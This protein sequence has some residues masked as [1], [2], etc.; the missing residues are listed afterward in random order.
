MVLVSGLVLAGG[1]SNESKSPDVT[2]SIR[3]SLDQAGLKDVSVS[4]D[5]D[6][7]VVTLS[8]SVASDSDKGQA[9]S[10]AKG[11]AGAMVVADQIAVRPPGAESMAKDIDADLDK[12]IEKNLDAALLQNHLN[13]E[14]S[15]DVK[16][17]VVTLTG[18][19]KSGERRAR[20][21]RVAHEVP[22]VKQVVNELDVKGHKATSSSSS[23]D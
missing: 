4:E 20:A 13:H 23:M 18:T 16:R 22:N 6:K 15:Y 19:V 2:N 9:E 17:G 21:E 1:C 14:V 11:A 8:G 7:G 10:I 12:A 5:R 3:S